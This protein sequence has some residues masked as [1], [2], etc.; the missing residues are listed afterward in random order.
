[1]D[2]NLYQNQLS[3]KKL[4]FIN[5][6]INYKM[7]ILNMKIQTLYDWETKQSIVPTAYK[8]K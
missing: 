7:E 8:K 1:M 5:A 6:Q 4:D 2:L 3:S